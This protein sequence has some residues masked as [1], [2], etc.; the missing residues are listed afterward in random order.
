MLAELDGA[1]YLTT[2]IG[3]EFHSVGITLPVADSC[4][5]SYRRRRI[6]RSELHRYL[7]A[8]PELCAGEHRHTTFA[9]RC[10]PGVHNRSLPFI[11]HD[12]AKGDI[13]FISIPAAGRGGN[14]P[15]AGCL[16][17]RLAS[18]YLSAIFFTNFT[19]P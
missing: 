7:V 2:A 12:D 6:W 4:L 5:R 13:H 1:L 8:R 19:L 18:H 10:P 9:Q 3:E 15:T 17:P 16:R 11:T 14:T